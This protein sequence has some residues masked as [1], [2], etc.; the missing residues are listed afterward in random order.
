[1][2]EKIT[3]YTKKR[4]HSEINTYNS[5]SH[6]NKKRKIIDNLKD[7]KSPTFHERMLFEP[8][9][10]FF[11]KY[12]KGKLNVNNKKKI[13][14]KCLLVLCESESIK[15]QEK[16]D[17][18]AEE[19]YTNMG[20]QKYNYIIQSLK[21]VLIGEI[22][23][24]CNGKN[25]YDYC[26]CG[27]KLKGG[28]T[29]CIINKF[30]GTW[31]Y[32]GKS[33]FDKIFNSQDCMKINELCEILMSD[34]SHI[35]KIDMTF[36]KFMEKELVKQNENLIKKTSSCKNKDDYTKEEIDLI[37]RMY[38][39][40]FYHTK[41][42]NEG[43]RKEILNTI[44]KLRIKNMA[45]VYLNKEII[46]NIEDLKSKC[47]TCSL[48]FD[49]S[50]LLMLGDK[51]TDN[52]NICKSCYKKTPQ[53][54]HCKMFI[55]KKHLFHTNIHNSCYKHLLKKKKDMVGQKPA[56]CRCCKKRFELLEINKLMIQKYT[57]IGQVPIC[58]S[59][60]N[61]LPVC[62][63]CKYKVFNRDLCKYE[64]G[65]IHD[66]CYHI[67]HFEKSKEE[68]KKEILNPTKR[69]IYNYDPDLIK[70][71]PCPL[72]GDLFENNSDK[73][74]Y[75]QEG[76]IYNS[77]CFYCLGEVRTQIKD[78]DFSYHSKCYDDN[79]Y[80]YFNKMS[81]VYKTIILGDGWE[82]SEIKKEQQKEQLIHAYVNKY[83]KYKKINFNTLMYDDMDGKGWQIISEKDISNIFNQI[84]TKFSF[85]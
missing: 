36:L 46:I 55:L 18:K 8:M 41:Y 40:I 64:D 1:M 51:D 67:Y 79:V 21:N 42:L 77:K 72:C 28:Q 66:S 76:F 83:G 39:E 2:Q 82:K 6:S 85:F 23:R 60:H 78:I 12:I 26:S 58:H 61:N 13:F 10:G 62:R 5:N 71:K 29:Y 47:F 45:T 68:C 57:D 34:T 17:K 74:D 19:I 70:K 22:I 75:C 80:K 24:K 38:H 11:S 4:S 3:K 54:L 52:Y 32:V 59:C 44:G 33:C 20:T 25:M 65:F 56:E 81:I 50:N 31:I 35:H 73:C 48:E 84:N 14:L 30:E 15:N 43:K 16:L 49:I 63:V 7:Y 37:Y 27:T 69:Q 53:C 9:S